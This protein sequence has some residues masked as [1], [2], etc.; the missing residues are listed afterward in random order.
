MWQQR[1]PQTSAAAHGWA[2]RWKFGRPKRREILRHNLLALNPVMWLVSRERWQAVSLWVVAIVLAGGF[3][4]IMAGTGQSMAWF[5]WSPVAGLVTLLLYLAIAAQAGRFFVEAQRCGLFELLLAT[6]LTGIQIVQ[7]QWRA[8]LRMFG[9]PVLVCL[10][11]QLMGAVLVQQRTWN[12]LASASGTA[13]PTPPAAATGWVTVRTTPTRTVNTVMVAPIPPAGA[14]VTNVPATPTTNRAVVN[15]G[16]PAV[17]TTTV[18]IPSFTP[19]GVV[20]ALV[21]SVGA[22]LSVAGNLAAL[23]WFG[24][25]MGLNSKNTNLATLKTI[26]FVLV[27]PWFVISFA[28]ALPVG[29]LM[30]PTIMKGGVSSASRLMM[31]F[32][33]LASAL[34]TVLALGKDV[35]FVLW[36]RHKLFSQFR[37]RAAHA[38]A[39]IPLSVP[40]LLPAARAGRMPSERRRG[41]GEG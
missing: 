36:A 27:I 9:L 31:W 34:A 26:L 41:G 21:I 20:V 11:A 18:S 4:G 32:P 37:E 13:V 40:P 6:P 28:S 22:T 23:G 2:Y 24:M 5:L 39:P 12:Q 3:V 25:W 10:A 38:L 19:P 7:G 29:L 8:L 14:T 16:G 17:T 33:L 15:L 35:G 30:I 1:A